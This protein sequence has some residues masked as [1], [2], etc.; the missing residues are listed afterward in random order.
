MWWGSVGVGA[1]GQGVGPGGALLLGLLAI[2]RHGAGDLGVR[3]PGP[4]LH[5]DGEEVHAL[6]GDRLGPVGGELARAHGAA[7]TVG[8]GTG[9]GSGGADLELILALRGLRIG[10]RGLPARAGSVVLSFLG[11]GTGL[12]GVVHGLRGPTDERGAPGEEQDEQQG[13]NA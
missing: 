12:D 13:D 7:G 3:R 6:G 4:V 5:G 10:G 9:L 1:G 11:R 2:A 8:H